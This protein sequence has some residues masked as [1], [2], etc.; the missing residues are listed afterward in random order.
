MRSHIRHLLGPAILFA[1]ATGARAFD[2]S[3]E[4]LDASPGQGMVAGALFSEANWMGAP[5]QGERQPAAARVVLVYRNLPAGRYAVSVFQDENGNGRLDKNVVGLPTE[6]YGFSRDA[7]ALLGPP[8][9]GEAA[10]DVQADTS[11]TVHLR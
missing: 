5:L 1:A 3:V 11:I 7:P 8:S 4:V 10:F 2:L 9:F 6:R